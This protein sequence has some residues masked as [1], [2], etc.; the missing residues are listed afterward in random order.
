LG[1]DAGANLNNRV[2]PGFARAVIDAGFELAGGFAVAS[3]FHGRG[4]MRLDFMVERYHEV[5]GLD[6]G[7]GHSFLLLYDAK[8]PR[9]QKSK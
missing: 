9:G 4:F 2:L 8:A 5:F 6:H 1:I 3:F 7:A